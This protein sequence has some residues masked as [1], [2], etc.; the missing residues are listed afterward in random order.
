MFKKAL[1][2]LFLVFLSFSLFSQ[3]TVL[4]YKWDFPE[5]NMV[6]DSQN[7]VHPELVKADQEFYIYVYKDRRALSFVE[8]K[9]DKLM[10]TKFVDLFDKKKAEFIGLNAR[11]SEKTGEIYIT[12]WAKQDWC[13]IDP[14]QPPYIDEFMEESIAEVMKKKDSLWTWQPAQITFTDSI[15]TIGNYNCKN[16]IVIEG[17]TVYNIWYTEQFDYS[18]CFF[19]YRFLIPGTVVKSERN[20]ETDFVLEEITY[21]QKIEEVLERVMKYR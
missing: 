8:S 11:K 21:P 2:P 14:L 7:V 18:W 12:P 1:L 16:A 6:K 4:K 3:Y 9:R 15:K 20:G 19:D 13:K 17:K 10:Q 5:I